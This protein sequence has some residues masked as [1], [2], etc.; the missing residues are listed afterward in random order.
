MTSRTASISTAFPINQTVI[1]FLLPH[2]VQMSAGMR[3]GI[4]FSLVLVLTCT[5]AAVSW[6]YIEKPALSLRK[7]ILKRPPA[8][9]PAIEARPEPQAEPRSSY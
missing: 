8:L 2:V 5:F 4:V 9:A 3:V 1:F 6:H 7:R